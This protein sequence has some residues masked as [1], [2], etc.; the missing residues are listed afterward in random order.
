MKASESWFKETQGKVVFARLTENGIELTLAHFPID[1]SYVINRYT[2]NDFLETF[3]K[4]LK[5]EV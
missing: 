1:K 2:V 3:P 4:V 5:E